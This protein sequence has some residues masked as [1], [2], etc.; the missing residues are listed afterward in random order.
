MIT[1]ADNPSWPGDIA[2][3]D[4]NSAGLPHESVVR[5]V[6]IA[7]L[8]AARATR[9]GRLEPVTRAKLAAAIRSRFARTG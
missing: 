7:T 2:I 3:P 8:A 4:P 9:I 5:P 1:S 6:K